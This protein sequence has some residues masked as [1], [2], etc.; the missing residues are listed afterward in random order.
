MSKSLHAH[1]TRT[2][3]AVCSM[4]GVPEA[5]WTR[6]ARWAD[7]LVGSGLHDELDRYVDMMIADRCYRG[8]D[9]LLNDLIMIG[10]DGE[11]LM[12]EEIQ[13]AVRT[14]LKL[15]RQAEIATRGM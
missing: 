8:T 6:F 12:T 1:E 5:D 4:L 15:A 10:V 13:L 9:D 2:V 11:D 14:M 7:D 3:R